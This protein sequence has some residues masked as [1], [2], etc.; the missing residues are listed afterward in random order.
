M[1]GEIQPCPWSVSQAKLIS[2]S[3]LMGSVGTL[4]AS[5]AR[6]LLHGKD[7]LQSRFPR[8]VWRVAGLPPSTEQPVTLLKIPLGL[9]GQSLGAPSPNMADSPGCESDPLDST[10]SFLRPT[11]TK[12]AAGLVSR[13]KN[14]IWTPY[15]TAGFRVSISWLCH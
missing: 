14:R 8:L 13:T 2:Q 12:D 1:Q 11:N 9:E 5:P 3:K 10:P 7:V 15:S 4:R 6:L